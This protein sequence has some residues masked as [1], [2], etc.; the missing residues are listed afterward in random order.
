MC[1]SVSPQTRRH[2]GRYANWESMG[3]PSADRFW[4]ALVLVVFGLPLFIGLGRTDVADDEAIEA[5]AVD[6]ILETGKWLAPNS[7]PDD[8]I[9]FVEK[10]HLKFWIV[11]APIRLGLLPHN[12]F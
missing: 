3:R 12:E 7:S 1:G 9:T 2:H 6:S 11:A 8:D 10:P 4:P 5:Y